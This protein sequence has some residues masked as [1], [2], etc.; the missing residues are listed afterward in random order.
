M[1]LTS[2]IHREDLFN[3]TERWLCGRLKPD[4]GLRITQILICDGFVLGET[5]ETMT[6]LLLGMICEGPCLLYTSPSPRD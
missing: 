5:L 4:D 3:I 1:Y 6:N 2:F